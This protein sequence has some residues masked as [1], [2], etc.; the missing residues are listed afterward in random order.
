MAKSAKERIRNTFYMEMWDTYEIEKEE[1]ITILKE[2][3]Y[4]EVFDVSLLRD[5]EEAINKA[6]T[7]KRI[8]KNM[9]P[10]PRSVCPMPNCNGE[11]IA[12]SRIGSRRW[13][14]SDTGDY[15]WIVWRISRLKALSDLKHKI[16]TE[17]KVGETI[18]QFIK[19]YEAYG[20]TENRKETS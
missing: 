14:C 9:K 11:R 18:D 19:D 15:C 1:I 4:T 20:R 6:G 10:F 16:I 3:G 17:D 8:K 12:Y 2:A 5:Y 13:F 7:M